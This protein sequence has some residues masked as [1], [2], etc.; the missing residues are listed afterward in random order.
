MTKPYFFGFP[1]SIKGVSFPGKPRILT[2]EVQGVT[3]NT[4]NY[5]FNGEPFEF[6]AN[7]PVG[8]V[9]KVN[10]IALVPGVV[11]PLGLPTFVQ[12]PPAP[13]IVNPFS[14]DMKNR[15]YAWEQPV[16]G[17]V[18]SDGTHG[19]AVLFL[20]IDNAVKAF[21]NPK[22]FQY[23]IQT[24]SHGTSTPP[25]PPEFIN[26]LYLT[27]EGQPFPGPTINATG[28]LNTQS[29]RDNSG[30]LPGNIDPTS[31]EQVSEFGEE[32]GGFCDMYF[33]L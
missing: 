29:F 11:G 14:T 8:P 4:G 25:G 5:A 10:G 16:P 24:S 1:S 22:T 32:V 7:P 3:P 13:N 31:P 27:G 21:N 6:F 9:N 2:A 17:F 30:F 19:A 28:N 23:N 15:L 20:D 12:P 33:N 26:Y 18:S